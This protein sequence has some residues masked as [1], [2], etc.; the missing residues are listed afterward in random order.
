MAD[1]W[2][3]LIC[4][5]EYRGD[6]MS[7]LYQLYGELVYSYDV[8]SRLVV[9]RDTAGNTTQLDYDPLGRKLRMVDPDKGAWHYRYDLL[10]NLIARP[11][12]SASSPG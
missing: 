9:V 3:N 2:G 8:Q 1:E 12:R 10:S 6:G 7:Q 4:V 11:M 5:R